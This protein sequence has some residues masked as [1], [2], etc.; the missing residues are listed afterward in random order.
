MDAAQEQKIGRPSAPVIRTVIHTKERRF[1]FDDVGPLERL[2]NQCGSPIEYVPGRPE[3]RITTI[4][5]DTR[6]GTW[7]AGR[8]RTKFR[9]KNYQDANFLWF[10][11]KRKEGVKV[12][13]WRHPLA[14]AELPPVLDGTRRGPVLHKFIGHTPLIPLVAVRYRRLAYE[15]GTL[16]LTID[17]DISFFAVDPGDPWSVGRALGR[18]AGVV[19]EV[20]SDNG[21]PAWLRPAFG[22]RRRQRFSKSRWALLA[23][24]QGW[25]G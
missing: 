12:D 25:Q 13:K 21:I 4:Y 2:V 6:E 17:R 9:C 5:L 7:S 3:T 1:L 24:N 16:R 15:W 20:K 23:K 11:I 18:K 10:E 22:G 8:S 14:F 19:V